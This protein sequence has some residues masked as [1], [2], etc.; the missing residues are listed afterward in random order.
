MQINHCLRCNHE[1]P[2]KL[3]KSRTCSK[4][5]SPYWDVPKGAVNKPV[6]DLPV[7]IKKKSAAS[8]V[9]EKS[10]SERAQ[11]PLEHPE[12][13]LNEEPWC[14]RVPTDYI[15]H[16]STGEEPRKSLHPE[17]TDEERK[18]QIESLK[19]LTN[20]E[21][22]KK[23]SVLPDYGKPPVVEDQPSYDDYGP[24]IS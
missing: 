17:R 11:L 5:R 23:E 7:E 9:L 20:K 2:S 16:K 24:V 19:S 15:R 22:Y 3:E 14:P 8:P 6:A 21:N 4:C 18:A 13:P 10:Y 1:W 12:H